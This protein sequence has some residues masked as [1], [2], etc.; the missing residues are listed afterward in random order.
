MSILSVFRNDIFVFVDIHKGDDIGALSGGVS[1]SNN[2]EVFSPFSVDIEAS[3]FSS[4]LEIVIL[5]LVSPC[6]DV[7]ADERYL[8][9]SN[10]P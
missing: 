10:D 7:E 9:I 2:E 1:L 4:I 8:S 3:C 6:K 5:A